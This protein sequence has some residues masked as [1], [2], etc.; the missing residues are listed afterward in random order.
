MQCE[1]HMTTQVKNSLVPSLNDGILRTANDKPVVSSKAN[2]V[3]IFC[4]ILPD[5]WNG[6]ALGGLLRH[7]QARNEDFEGSSPRTGTQQL[8][9]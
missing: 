8:Y 2:T 3:L 1:G 5:L 6:T 9:L 7:I 4:H